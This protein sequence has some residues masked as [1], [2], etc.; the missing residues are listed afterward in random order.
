MCIGTPETPEYRESEEE[1]WARG[2]SSLFFS[3]ARGKS[4]KMPLN[5]PA[6]TG[7][8][9]SFLITARTPRPYL[10]GDD[11]PATWRFLAIIGGGARRSVGGQPDK[12]RG[13]F[14]KQLTS[15]SFCPFIDFGDGVYTPASGTIR[16][17]RPRGEGCLSPKKRSGLRLVP[18]VNFAGW[19]NAALH[20]RA[21]RN[22]HLSLIIHARSALKGQQLAFLRPAL[23]RRTG[24]GEK[25]VEIKRVAVV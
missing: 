3:L 17:N 6:D 20:R 18:A 21:A 23:P 10:L 12:H 24:N 22:F 9:L 5:Y 4:I 16:S 1:S 8:R 11:T 7:A 14:T 19:L 15:P 13:L 25:K 2:S